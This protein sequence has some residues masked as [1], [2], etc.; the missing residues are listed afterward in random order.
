MARNKRDRRF[1]P[2][3]LGP[4]PYA[5][6]GTAPRQAPWQNPR[7]ASG[8]RLPAARRRRD[9]CRC[10]SALRFAE[11]EGGSFLRSSDAKRVPPLVA[12]ASCPRQS[13][14][15]RTARPKKNSPRDRRGLLCQTSAFLHC[16]CRLMLQKNPESEPVRDQQQRHNHSRKEECGSQLPR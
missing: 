13:G 15:Y 11:R 1:G 5:A 16:G 4:G 9:A 14:V 2:G 12:L 3:S 10:A 7:H 6:D 8:N